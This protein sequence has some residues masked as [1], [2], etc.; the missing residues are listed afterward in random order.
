MNPNLFI[1]TTFAPDNSKISEVLELCA[2]HGL[3]NLELGS[4]HCYEPEFVNI[5]KSFACQYEQSN[6]LVHN[7]FPIPKESFVLNIA[8]LDEEIRK[9]SIQHIFKAIDF[10]REIGAKL[11]TFH[12]GFLTDPK[13]ASQEAG[14]YDFRFDEQQLFLE[15]YQ[16]A[17]GRMIE[18]IR[19]VVDYAKNKQVKIAIETEG[20][21][22]KKDHLLMQRPE[23]YQRFFQ[24][25]S[26]E[27][28]GINLN[29]GHLILA[30]KAFSFEQ[31]D[32]VDLVAPYV[33][34]MELSHNQ[35]I[36]DD[37]LPL[38]EEAWYWSIIADPRFTDAYKIV[39][40]RNTSIKDIL[41]NMVLFRAQS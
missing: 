34:A 41:E 3:K 22:S 40:T 9:K 17:F 6:F 23:E 29:L 13:G 36:N 5:I 4:N 12:P 37:H 16:Q 35:G 1:S 14:N 19:K 39:E 32:F 30:S 28:I 15:K 24:H 11:Y 2:G 20:S 27:D 38:K 33:V 25:F 31:K 26:P 10:C 21:I 7:Y 18:S 8:S